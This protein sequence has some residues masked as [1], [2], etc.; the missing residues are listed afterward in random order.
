[1]V[2][3]SI[4]V[5]VSLLPDLPCHVVY[6]LLWWRGNVD[7]FSKTAQGTPNHHETRIERHL[8]VLVQIEDVKEERHS[9]GEVT[10]A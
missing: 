4:P 10:P 9:L 8:L 7:H 6:D 5:F 1:M 3:A 2:D